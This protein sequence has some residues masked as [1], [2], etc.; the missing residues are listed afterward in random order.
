VATG[1][2]NAYAHVFDSDGALW[3][4]EIAESIGDREAPDELNRV[5]RGADYGWPACVGDRQPVASFGGDGER[6]QGTVRPVAEFGPS[7]TA[8]SI[9]VNPFAD[10]ELIVTLWVTGQVVSVEADGSSTPELFIEGL[11]RPQ[12]LLVDGDTLLVADHQQGAIYR[13]S[14]R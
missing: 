3:T 8:T 10:G 7:A 5:E 2:K 13:V 14:E 1:L 11:P 6:C 9:V 12:S 4:T